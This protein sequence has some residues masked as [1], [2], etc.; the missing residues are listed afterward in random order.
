MSWPGW[1][2]TATDFCDYGFVSSQVNCKRLFTEK[3]K[4]ISSLL[5]VLS[6]IFSPPSSVFHWGGEFSQL[7]GGRCQINTRSAAGTSRQKSKT[8]ARVKW[9]V[10]FSVPTSH[11]KLES[12]EK[13][14]KHIEISDSM[15]AL[16]KCSILFK[17]M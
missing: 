17:H 12:I 6:A 13:I 14:T 5:L 1:L 8:A 10:P 16:E 15:V 3:H 7:V 9:N 2:K 11:C 4:R